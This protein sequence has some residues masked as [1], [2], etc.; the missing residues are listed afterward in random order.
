M[1]T[2]FQTV[3]GKHHKR[4]LMLMLV[5]MVISFVFVIGAV[6]RG[7]ISQNQRP[8]IM[9]MGV[10]LNDESELAPYTAATQEALQLNG[11]Y[12]LTQQQ[13]QDALFTRIAMTYLSNKWQIPEAPQPWVKQYIERVPVFQDKTGVFDPSRYQAVRDEVM[14][15]TP[16]QQAAFISGLSENARIARMIEAITGPGYAL[17]YDAVI[18]MAAAL[19]K[20]DIDVATLDFT[21]FE[22]KVDVDDKALE[23]FFNRDPAHYQMPAQFQLSY[24]HFVTP[25][26][27]AQPTTEQLS[28][29]IKQNAQTFPG[30]DPAKPGDKTAEATEAWRKAQGAARAAQNAA[31]FT[32]ALDDSGATRNSPAFGAIMSKFGAKLET[33]APYTP[34]KG[35]PVGSPAS[36][37]ALLQGMKTMQAQRQFSDPV[38]VAD[39]AVVIF[40]DGMTE[41]HVPKYDE[42]KDDVL[43][44]YKQQEKMR[45]F[46]ALGQ[47]DRETMLKDMASGKTFTEAAQALGMT[48]KHYPDISLSLDKMPEGMSLEL[49]G[50]LADVNGAGVPLLM[51]LPAG[52]TSAMFSTSDGGQWVH[53]N[54][55]ETPPVSV[56]SPDV[57][58]VQLHNAD[59]EAGNN[60]AILSD[61][62]D[63]ARQV[64]P[65][66]KIG[67]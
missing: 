5:I 63:Q 64:L 54:K 67:Q 9:Y 48:V 45:Q 55:R 37:D 13:F 53:V 17:P 31:D 62:V 38:R 50:S 7:A 34:G 59:A 26:S 33:L 22:P 51:T 49:F 12:S 6:P 30:V 28:D 32:R 14:K 24:V 56:N 36:D 16:D 2:W 19:T 11:A 8:P 10:N 41:A 29:F 15:S 39:G 25:A 35:A 21:T 57:Q 4:I 23:A 65:S 20:W 1:I 52:D 18:S 27:D 60:L 66:Q 44:Y 58:K 3:F 42:V 40:L 43:A 46:M 47:Q 61:I